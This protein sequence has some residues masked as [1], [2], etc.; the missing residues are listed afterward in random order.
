MKRILGCLFLAAA[1]L[2]AETPQELF[3]KAL[4]KERS[5]GNLKEAIR[6][7]K[8]TA[9]TAGKDRALAANALLEAGKCYLKTGDAEAR[10]LF[11]RV[12]RD[13]SDQKE[14]VTLARA[15]LAKEPGIRDIHMSFRQ[16]WN[17]PDQADLLGATSRD[18]RYIPYVDWADHGNLFVHD[19]VLDTNRR[20]TDTANNDLPGAKVWEAA[21]GDASFSRDGKQLIYSYGRGNR[22][23]LRLI[24]MKGDGIPQSR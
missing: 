6:L 8:R 5:E 9:E 20:L 18:G 14:A 11:E 24:D 3:E 2:M 7:Y 15:K 4:V 16:L 12:I 19:L 17:V 13:Y 23:E 1:A 10:K 22:Y 21:D